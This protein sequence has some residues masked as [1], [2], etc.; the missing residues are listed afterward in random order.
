MNRN[1]LSIA[2]LALFTAFASCIKEKEN[3]IPAPPVVAKPGSVEMHFENKSG[4]EELVF[5]Q[6]YKTEMGDSF[7]VS[8]F[9]YYISNIVL[10]TSDG[11]TY[12]EPESYHLI[13]HEDAGSMKFMI[14][15]VPPGEYTQ[16]S[17]MIGVDSTRNVSGAQTGALDPIHGMFWTWNTGYIMAKLE[18]KAPKS[19]GMEQ[20]LMYHVG[21]FKGENNV[22]KSVNIQLAHSEKVNNNEVHLTVSADVKK[23]FHGVNHIDFATTYMIH[24]P[25]EAANKIAANYANMFSIEHHH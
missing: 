19:G 10:T 21:G 12:A 20:K 13:K 7:Q 1:K 24:M 5:G 22:V 14:N 23:W 16:V 11:K 8:L 2:A 17:F 6:W 25:G 3:V 4:E 18:G 15:N 9:N